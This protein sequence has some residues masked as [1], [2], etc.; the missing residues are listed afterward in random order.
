[1]LPP[2][3][4]GRPPH[5][6]VQG[7]VVYLLALIL[8]VQ[9]VYPITAYGTLAVVAYQFLYASMIVVGVIVGRDSPRHQAILVG[10]GTI[11]LVAGLVYALN[12]AAGWAVLITYLALIPYLAM[13]LLVLLRFVFVARAIT[14]DVLYAATAVYLLLGALFVPIYGLL[15]TLSPGAFR[16]GA[17][18]EA[19]VQWQQLIYYSYVTLSTA[20][21]GD[22]LPISMWARSLANLEMLVGVLYITIVMA[23]L[24]GLYST[25]KRSE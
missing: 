9:S 15:E 10:A 23:R 21:Y 25:E 19:P 17:L 8:L 4:A 6:Y 14:R 24:V 22:V 2:S 13:L 3:G 1:M 18:P 11:Y 12:P 20:G 7:K 16:D 5:E